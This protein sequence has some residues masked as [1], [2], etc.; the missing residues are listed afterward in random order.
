MKRSI[1]IYL[2]M[3]CFMIFL[4]GSAFAAYQDTNFTV[5]LGFD[6]LGNAEIEFGS[7]LNEDEDV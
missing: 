6:V 1:S 7:V 3:F 2:M 4:S 5:L